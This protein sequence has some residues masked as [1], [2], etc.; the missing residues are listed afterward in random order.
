[1]RSSFAAKLGCR[2]EHHPRSRWESKECAVTFRDRHP[3]RSRIKKANVWRMDMDPMRTRVC[4]IQATLVGFVSSRVDISGINGYLS[5]TTDLAPIVLHAAIPD[6]RTI[7]GS[8]ADVPAKSKT[9][10]KAAM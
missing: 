8:D 3:D 4:F 10:W 7:N 6:P 1:M 9:A 2:T 5:T